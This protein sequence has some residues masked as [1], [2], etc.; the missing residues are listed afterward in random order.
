[1][2]EVTQR[3]LSIDE[4]LEIMNS[5]PLTINVV[6]NAESL[7]SQNLGSEIDRNFVVRFNWPDFRSKSKKL[8]TRANWILTSHPKF[9]RMRIPSY[10][11]ESNIMISSWGT[12]DSRF[13]RTN[14]LP[15]NT[16]TVLPKE[17]VQ[18]QWSLYVQR[19]DKPI[20][21]NQKP[22][23]GYFFLQLIN[24]YRKDIKVNIYGFDF[25][26]TKSFYIPDRMIRTKDE[27]N[28]S[29][30]YNFEKEKVLELCKQNNWNI[31]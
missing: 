17:V 29:H 16:I 30:N 19:P 15:N 26:D 23:T 24:K 2:K 31:L 5:L 4:F 25:K 10:Y 9:A 27:K 14:N 11:N 22:S 6:G 8:G 18:E 13:T 21:T 12:L 28:H 20:S 7:L 3:Q 1:M